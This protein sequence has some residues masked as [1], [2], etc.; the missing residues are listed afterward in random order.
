MYRELLLA[1]GLMPCLAM[2][3]APEAQARADG[4]PPAAATSPGQDRD[5]AAAH[6]PQRTD[7]RLA[8]GKG[9]CFSNL[10]SSYDAGQLDS[11]GASNPAD[12]L[13]LLD[14]SVTIRR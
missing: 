8:R 10:G 14:P 7:G 13:H 9:A 11:T 4:T 5:A 1:L 6:C 2:A 12:A 3:A